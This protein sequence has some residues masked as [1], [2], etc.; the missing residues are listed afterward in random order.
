MIVA[1]LTSWRVHA[2]GL[3]SAMASR[4]R[5]IAG[6]GRHRLTKL[7]IA[8][9]VG[10]SVILLIAATLLLRSLAATH[11]IDPGFESRNVLTFRSL[12]MLPA[13]GAAPDVDFFDRL[14]ARLARLPGVESVGSAALLPF[15]R[16]GQSA[17][18]LVPGSDRPE[19]VAFRAVS[20]RYFDTLEIAIREGRAFTEGDSSGAPPVAI[21]NQAFVDRYLPGAPPISVRLPV[22]SRGRALERAIV[23]V[24]AD[25]R[26]SRLF[27]DATPTLYAPIAQN[28]MPM[29]QFAVRTTGD[30]GAMAAAIR[31]AAAEI[32][33][34]QPLQDVISL[35]ALVAQTMEEERFYGVVSASLAAMAVLLAIAGLYGVVAL[36]VRRRDREVGIR[37]ALGSTRAAV[38]RLMAAE[39]MRPVV[40]GLIA[41]C[42][43]AAAIA[44][45]LR[46]LLHGIDA[47]D[48]LSY[49]AAAALFAVVAAAACVVPARH[50]ARVNPVEILR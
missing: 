34:G 19:A 45:W 47:V 46:S 10:L 22:R 1:L 15:S 18:V 36:A 8:V 44:H 21:V 43:A 16:W 25:V 13:P 17:T 11:A 24:A 42:G 6:G 5:G 23:G 49:F 31:R 20:W 35:D 50:A 7:T 12:L 30:P 26:E 39:G 4:A 33:P 29:R 40:V 2:A 3:A 48:P 9:Q 27:S 28:Q 14:E 41:G 37:M 38:Y 32:D